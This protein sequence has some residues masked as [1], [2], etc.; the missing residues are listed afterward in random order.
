MPP[1]RLLSLNVCFE[2]THLEDRTRALCLLLSRNSWDVIS[3]QEMTSPCYRRV[4]QT[5]GGTYDV[6]PVDEA[7]YF[8]VMLCAKSLHA[9]FS[10]VELTSRMGRDVGICEIPGRSLVVMNVHLESEDYQDVREIQLRECAKLVQDGF[11]RKNVLIV[12]DFNFPADRNYKKDTKP[13]HNECLPR[14]LPG[15]VDAWEVAHP[16]NPGYTFLFA[17]NAWKFPNASYAK[18]GFRFDRCMAKL[19]ANECAVDSIEVV[20]DRPIGTSPATGSRG[21]V[22]LY[23]SDHMG[24]EVVLKF[25]EQEKSRIESTEQRPLTRPGTTSSG[26]PEKRTKLQEYDEVEFIG[27]DDDKDFVDENE[28]FRR[29]IAASMGDIS[30]VT[31]SS[32]RD[33]ESQKEVLLMMLGDEPLTGTLIALRTTQG[34]RQKRRFSAD[35]PLAAVFTWAMTLDPAA[36]EEDAK[37]FQLRFADDGTVLGSSK[38]ENLDRTVSENGVGGRLLLMSF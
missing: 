27:S 12:G 1:L 2:H 29:A 8:T 9:K 10:R 25:T 19:E 33:G 13:L 23:I 32:S 22:P 7:G 31:K 5:C 28:F 3:L 15:F 6:S 18:T 36:M 35:A 21:N 17:N 20:L 24:L 38:N 14:C 16:G 26:A 11:A 34:S 4:V 37:P 30:S